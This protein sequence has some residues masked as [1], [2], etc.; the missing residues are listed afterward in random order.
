MK[1]KLIIEFRHIQLIIDFDNSGFSGEA[2]E[3]SWFKG[4]KRK[5]MRELAL[6]RDNSYDEFFCEAEKEK[7]VTG[8]TMLSFWQHIRG[9]YGKLVTYGNKRE[10]NKYNALKRGNIVFK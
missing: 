8:V 10:R 1:W 2:R 6:S 4:F 3:K 9:N 7:R 5:R